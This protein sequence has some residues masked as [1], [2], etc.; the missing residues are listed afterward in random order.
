[1]REKAVDETVL[2]E[3]GHPR[4]GA[5]QKVHPHGQ[6]DEHDHRALAR[7]AVPGDDEGERIGDDQADHR[8][9]EGQPHRAD[10]HR[11]VFAHLGDVVDRKG[12]V[13]G[14]HRVVGH[15]P[16]R[17]EDEDQHPDE[18]WERGRLRFH[19]STSIL[20]MMWI[21]KGSTSIPMKVPGCS[22]RVEWIIHL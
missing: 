18:V 10:K 14:G 7:A 8:G 6:H 16:E 12:P 21:S 15:Q 11:R 9:E 17:H 3:D 13:G 22:L 4:V 20:C 5:Q 2:L 1:M 19:P